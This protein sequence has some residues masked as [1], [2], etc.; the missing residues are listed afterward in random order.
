MPPARTHRYI[1]VHSDPGTVLSDL[2]TP[3][4][5]VLGARKSTAVNAVAV[6]VRRLVA[7][8]RRDHQPRAHTTAA[9]QPQCMRGHRLFRAVASSSP[10]VGHSYSLDRCPTSN[11][12]VLRDSRGIYTSLVSPW[13]GTTRGHLASGSVGT[14]WRRLSA[15][16]GLSAAVITFSTRALM[17]IRDRHE[18]W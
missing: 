9:S 14:A 4:F 7:T 18:S 5:L 16:T 3:R 8:T 12:A 17:M 10:T 6:G 11:D 15:P 13:L 2:D 1:D